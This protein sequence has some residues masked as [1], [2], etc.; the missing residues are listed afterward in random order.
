MVGGVNI[1]HVGQES[2][3]GRGCSCMIGRLSSSCGGLPVNEEIS[4]VHIVLGLRH[5]S[6]VGLCELMPWKSFFG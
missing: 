4:G 2:S 6:L 1:S 3:H 5:R